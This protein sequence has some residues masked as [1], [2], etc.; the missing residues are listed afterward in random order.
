MDP[1]Y[2][3]MPQVASQEAIDKLYK[4]YQEDLESMRREK[5]ALAMG[6]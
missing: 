2:Y 5:E 3:E 4:E 6:D 1:K